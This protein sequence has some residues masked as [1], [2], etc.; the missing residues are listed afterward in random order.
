[1]KLKTTIK[2][3]QKVVKNKQ[4][5]IE[6]GWENLGEFELLPAITISKHSVCIKWLFFYIEFFHPINNIFDK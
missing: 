2:N 4:L 6:W 3:I 5:V 1:M